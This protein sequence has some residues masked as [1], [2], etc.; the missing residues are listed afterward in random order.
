M[1]E[2]HDDVSDNDGEDRV[3]EH[4]V[5]ERRADTPRHG[6]EAEPLQHRTGGEHEDD[7]RG[8]ED[9]VQLLAG[10]ELVGFEGTLA[11]CPHPLDFTARPVV[12]STYVATHLT[13]PRAKKR[14]DDGNRQSEPAPEM[15]LGHEMALHDD[16]K[17]LSLIHISEPTRQ[18]EI[19]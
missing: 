4:V 7:H 14:H 6:K 18:A 3:G 13:S 19:S 10:V 9:G 8:D 1:G 16:A 15:N 17:E 2:G 12:D 11:E 5:D